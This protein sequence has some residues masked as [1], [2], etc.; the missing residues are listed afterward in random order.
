MESVK[1]VWG[2]NSGSDYGPFTDAVGASFFRYASSHL[3]M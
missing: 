2:H 3:P 1:S